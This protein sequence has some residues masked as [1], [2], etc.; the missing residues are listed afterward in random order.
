MGQLSIAQNNLALDNNKIKSLPSR[1]DLTGSR[2]P[3]AWENS[4]KCGTI[5]LQPFFIFENR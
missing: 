4:F 1:F 3:N 2:F 5:P